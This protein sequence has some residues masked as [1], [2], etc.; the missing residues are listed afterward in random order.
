[1]RAVVVDRYGGPEVLTLREQ[2]PPEPGAGQLVVEVAA[3]GVN[4]VDIY[5]RQGSPPYARELPYV[6]G[7]EGAGTVTAIGPGVDVFAVGDRVA[8]SGAP[9]SYAERV[10]VPVQRAVGVPASLAPTLAAAVMLQGMTA[11]YLATATYPVAPGDVAV[12]HAGAGGVGLLLTQI[13][14]MRGGIV[15]ATASTPG[16]EKLARTAGADHVTGYENFVAVVR[17]VTDGA[18]AAVVYDGVGRATFDHSLAA[19]RTRGHL[20][21]Y[22]GAS[23]PVPPLELQRLAAGGSLYIT[24]PTLIH[25]TATRAELLRRAGD[26]FTWIG[27]GELDVRIGGTYPLEQA[28]RAHGD[29]GSRRTSGKLLLLPR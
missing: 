10:A 20:V 1:M 13:I 7:S 21:L 25:Y 24:R 3:A 18:G 12:V 16:K 2:A 9:G 14:K 23:G 17:E 29:L 4:F 11:H 8:W 22:G 26:L 5:M 27:K 15:I 28:A 19:V 6:P